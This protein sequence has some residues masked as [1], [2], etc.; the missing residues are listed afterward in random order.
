MSGGI[1]RQQSTF[2]ALR[3]LK[4]QKGI[5]KVLIHD[6]ARPNFSIKL[7]SS[8]IK[9]MKKSKAV[10]PKI[11]IQDAIKEIIDFNKEEYIVGKKEEFVSN[12]DTSGI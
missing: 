1:N 4:N 12:P 3:Y 5:S 11:E 6:A 8:I 2:N 10:V 7:I 9:N